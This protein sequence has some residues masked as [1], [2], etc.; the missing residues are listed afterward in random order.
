MKN[1]TVFQQGR[2]LDLHTANKELRAEILKAKQSYKSTLE[3]KMASNSLGSALSS[4]KTIT[5]LHNSREST[6]VTL[7]GFSSDTVFASA[8]NCF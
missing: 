1:K 8:L 3:N 6:S 7:N 5:G 2:A 4:M